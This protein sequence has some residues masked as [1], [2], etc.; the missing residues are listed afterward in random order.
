[1][2]RSASGAA[3]ADGLLLII[4]IDR[5]KFPAP[6]C[7]CVCVSD[8]LIPKLCKSFPL[9]RRPTTL[10]KHNPYAPAV[11]RGQL[12][13]ST[14]GT[15]AKHEFPAPVRLQLNK[16][17]AEPPRLHEQRSGVHQKE[18]ERIKNRLMRAMS[19]FLFVFYV[20]SFSWWQHTDVSALSVWDS[21]Y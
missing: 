17:S 1:M 5:N 11:V 9:L 16:T 13:Y 21:G 2:K 4:A 14:P 7:V 18:K 20:G 6:L 15:N 8:G 19:F 3:A 12:C 10:S